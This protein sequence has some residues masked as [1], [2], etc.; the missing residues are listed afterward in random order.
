MT[1]QTG[2]TGRVFLAT[3]RLLFCL[4]CVKDARGQV[5]FRACLSRVAICIRLFL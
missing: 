1:G 5:N 4:Q 3:T 2:Q